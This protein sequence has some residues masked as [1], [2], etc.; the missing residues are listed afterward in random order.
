MEDIQAAHMSIVPTDN[1]HGC[2]R[3]TQDCF[4][5]Q[6]VVILCC[7]PKTKYCHGKCFI[8]EVF[9]GLLARLSEVVI[10]IGEEHSIMHMYHRV[11]HGPW[12]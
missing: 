3:L 10:D 12:F 5:G 11:F 2:I 1:S 4:K 7:R 8:E 6:G 9:Q